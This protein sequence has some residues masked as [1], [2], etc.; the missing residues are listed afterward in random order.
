[1]KV[2]MII[3]THNRKNNLLCVLAALSKQTVQPDEIIVVDDRSNDGTGQAFFNQ[4]GGVP[5]FKYVYNPPT[6]VGWNASIP[7]NLG[8]KVVSRDVDLLWFLDSDVILPPNAVEE[9][10]KAY[11]TGSDKRVLIGAY[12]SLVPQEFTAQD[13]IDRFDD[14]INNKFPRKH[15]DQVGFMTNIKDIRQVSFD[16]AATSQEEFYS[17]TDALACFGGY[18]LIPK[19]IFYLAGGYDEEIEA[20]CEDGDFGITLYETGIKFSYLKESCGYHIPHQQ[21]S[22]RTNVEIVENVRK[23]NEK[24]NVDMI[25]QSGKAYRKWGIDWQPPGEFYDFDEKKLEE[26]KKLWSEINE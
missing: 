19:K 10:L 16:K 12:H 23:L 3:P 13:V 24:H 18:L 26:Y 11:Q 22:G 6:Y 8:A 5:L 15:F 21:P 25:H 4:Y 1:M 9:T 20:G 14:V 7:R 2:A 17:F